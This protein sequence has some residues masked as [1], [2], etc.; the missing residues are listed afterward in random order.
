MNLLDLRVNYDLKMGGSRLSLALDIFN[1]LNINSITSID[2]QSGA[3]YARIVD[4]IAP[5]I[6]RFGVRMRF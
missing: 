6:L 3:N 1:A 5:R 4:F 2:T